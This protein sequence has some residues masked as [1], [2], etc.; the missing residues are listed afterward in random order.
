LAYFFSRD[1]FYTYDIAQNRAT[2]PL[3]TKLNWHGVLQG[4]LHEYQ[5]DAALIWPPR[6]Q[7]G[8]LVP[9]AY[10]FQTDLYYRVDVDSRKVD[11]GYPLKT[12]DQWPGLWKTGQPFVAAFVWPKP[13]NGR[14]KAYFFHHTQY[15]RY[16]ILDN[17]TDDGY[18]LPIHGNWDGL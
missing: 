6:P 1:R 2:G 7:D 3:P 12:P 5:V 9:K 17:S 4:P 10:F 11:A 8:I 16:D 14:M 18:P 15:L 13:V